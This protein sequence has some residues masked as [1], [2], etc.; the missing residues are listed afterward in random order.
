MKTTV[1]SLVTALLLIGMVGCGSGGG[2]GCPEDFGSGTLQLTVASGSAPGLCTG[3]YT[4]TNKYPGGTPIDA[5]GGGIPMIGAS[6]PHTVNAS[7]VTIAETDSRWVVQ[8][9][10][11]GC[12]GL[13]WCTQSSSSSASCDVTIMQSSTLSNTLESF[14]CTPTT[15]A[16]DGANLELNCNT[17]G[18]INTSAAISL[19]GTLTH[20]SSCKQ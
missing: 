7:N 15:F 20:A 9:S 10:D 2:S 11:G 3:G 8:S 4:T 16:A 18:T 13:V 19:S 17:Q 1:Q 5:N 12:V 6:T 14:A